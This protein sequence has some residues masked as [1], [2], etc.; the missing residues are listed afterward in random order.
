MSR[1][2]ERIVVTEIKTNH[3]VEKPQRQYALAFVIFVGVSMVDLWLQE[4]IGYEA[5][6]LVNLLTV[7]VIA[8]F[9]SRGPI[10]FGTA[11][12]AMGWNFFAAPPRFSFHISSFY[13]KMMMATYFVV[14]LT[15]GHLTTRLR[16]QRETEMKAKLLAESERLS[17]TLLS[18]V[19]HELRTP[20]ATIVGA[21]GELRSFG[22]LA[23]M[24]KR[25]ADEIEVASLRLNRVVQSLLSA[26]RI[27]SGQ[28]RAKMDWCDISDLVSVTMHEIPNLE[29]THSVQI[30]MAKGLPLV[31]MDFVL[32]GQALANLLLNAVTHTPPGTIVEINARVEEKQLY[33]QVSDNGPGLPPDQLESVFNSFHRAA[34]ASPGGTGLGLA[35]VKGFVEAQGGHVSASNRLNGGAIFTIR[36]PAIE[37]PNLPP[38]SR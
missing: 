4:L 35:I 5:I 15:I 1:R 11:L 33:L 36:I 34:N 9:L 20:I 17:R 18:S 16:A 13:D 23:P 38:D 14:A 10:L 32:M 22:T 7:V 21:A 12:T 31:K 37:T 6:A 26:A 2:R 29:L 28:V 27:K 19:S 25:L 3:L 30:K 8:L 24:Q